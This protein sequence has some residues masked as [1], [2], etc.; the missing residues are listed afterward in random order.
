LFV[1]GGPVETAGWGAVVLA[2]IGLIGLMFRLT[3]GAFRREVQQLRE[4]IDAENLEADR[5]YFKFY[6]EFIQLRIKIAKYI[7]I[8]G[9]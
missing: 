5:K 3:V 9:D 4:H 1:S 8:N 2:L 7:G 6:K